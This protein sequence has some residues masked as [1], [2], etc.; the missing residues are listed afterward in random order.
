MHNSGLNV[1]AGPSG[2]GK[3]SRLLEELFQLKPQT[4]G[5]AVLP[6]KEQADEL[7]STLVGRVPFGGS[8]VS[9][10]SL[11][12]ELSG[13]S[14]EEVTAG[15]VRLICLSHVLRTL[16]VE[17][18]F[19]RLP[20]D[21]SI[22]QMSRLFREMEE[23]A[24]GG[25]EVKRRLR[26]TR[27]KPMPVAEVYIAYRA[28]LEKHA[29][30]TVELETAS[31]AE[32]ILKGKQRLD[33]T[34]FM[35]DDFLR[36]SRSQ[37]MLIRALSQR[38]KTL[39]TVTCDGMINGRGSEGTTNQTEA[40]LQRLSRNGGSSIVRVERPA[41]VAS[42]DPEIIVADNIYSECIEILRRVRLLVLN[43]VDADDIAIVA[44]DPGLYHRP[45]ALAAKRL[46]I[47]LKARADIP[48]ANFLLVQ[49]FIDKMDS[50][51]AGV[52]PARTQLME[53]SGLVSRF[54]RSIVTEAVGDD[55]ELLPNI[56]EEACEK[57][58]VEKTLFALLPLSAN[59]LS[60]VGMLRDLLRSY[61]LVSSKLS[62]GRQNHR[63]FWTCARLLILGTRVPVAGDH[64]GVVFS[65]PERLLSAR[66][67]HVF[68]AG[69]SEG[70][71]PVHYDPGAIMK[72]SQRERFNAGENLLGSDAQSIEYDHKL[73]DIL[74]WQ[75]EEG[76]HIS[77]PLQDLNG[78]PL[79]PSRFLEE[80]GYTEHLSD[81]P[82]LLRRAITFVPDVSDVACERDAVMIANLKYGAHSDHSESPRTKRLPIFRAHA[83]PGVLQDQGS[84]GF[85][86]ERKRYSVGEIAGYA[87]CPLRHFCQYTLRLAPEAPSIY[88]RE[89][90]LM[91]EALANLMRGYDK[92]PSLSA[93]QAFALV[94][95][96]LIEAHASKRPDSIVSDATLARLLPLL[97]RFAVSEAGIIHKSK[98]KP[99]GFELSMPGK[100][101]EQFGDPGGAALTVQDEGTELHISG[102]IDRVDKLPDGTFA[103]LDYKLSTLPSADL[104]DGKAIQ[105]LLYAASLERVYEID[106]ELAE[107]VSMTGLHRRVAL[108]S[109]DKS[110][111]IAHALQVAADAVSSIRNG[112]LALAEDCPENCDLRTF[113]KKEWA[114]ELFGQ[115]SGDNSPCGVMTSGS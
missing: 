25:E 71:F 34:L 46:G 110:K 32:M 12:S 11:V 52:R 101:R 87:Q 83:R 63:W 20:L 23:A 68:A 8:A 10:R 59:E 84:L 79:L 64:S 33:D 5:I 105:V 38:S 57:A 55:P 1:I 39:L 40:C 37:E 65:S 53:Q 27:M 113:C 45:I 41:D 75:P 6:S 60:A 17:S 61:A 48:L 26:E 30:R 111:K 2:S 42:C 62:D 58:G 72:N 92:I 67:K 102:R 112:V 56:F 89:G 114:L 109:D 96:K 44:R 106:I 90:N 54:A 29:W 85:I 22:G 97:L 13:V 7:E 15:T 104:D 31:V 24:L 78:H 108:T 69:L 4:R 103:V 74:R 94:R 50:E 19:R 100:T 98:R 28:F 66:V 88:L 70:I 18:K 76:L 43:G 16:P 51:I 95:E 81:P 93:S 49:S 21:V 14:T 115:G 82:G 73:L 77:F 35:F 3:T 47:P 86:R 9:F 107:Y 80:L 99:V 36:L 91:H